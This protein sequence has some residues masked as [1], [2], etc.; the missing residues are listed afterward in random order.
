[1]VAHSVTNVTA[2]FEFVL[3]DLVFVVFLILVR[4]I[5]AWPLP[6]LMME[7]GG[8]SNTSLNVDQNT[9][10]HM[11]EDINCSSWLP[12]IKE[13]L[14]LQC[15]KLSGCVP[16]KC[17]WTI[18]TATY[19]VRQ[20]DERCGRNR[21][22]V[23]TEWLWTDCGYTTAIWERTV[24]DSFVIVGELRTSV[25]R[26]ERRLRVLENGLLRGCEVLRGREQEK[27]VENGII[28]GVVIGITP[29]KLVRWENQGGWD[30]RG[31]WHVW[32]TELHAGF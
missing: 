23:R 8:F 30:W 16:Q 12:Q 14:S 32:G 7:A 17:V 19:A 31:M 9:R 27:T 3:W 29:P 11:P 22:A 26:G 4:T 15:P 6:T 2:W 21:T 1:M 25:L 20:N 10:R 5:E 18:C 24:L 28:R 13:F